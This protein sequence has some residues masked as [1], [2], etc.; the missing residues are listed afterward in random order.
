MATFSTRAEA[1]A[2]VATARDAVERLPV[3]SLQAMGPVLGAVAH[4]E[5]A[6][7]ATEMVEPERAAGTHRFRQV[8]DLGP[9]NEEGH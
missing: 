7:S 5:A 8:H 6:I 3:S 4:L 1:L 9:I 2:A